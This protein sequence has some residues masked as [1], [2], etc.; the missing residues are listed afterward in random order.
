MHT[1]APVRTPAEILAALAAADDADDAAD[2]AAPEL[3]GPDTPAACAFR[4]AALARAITA[5]AGR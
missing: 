5:A 3:T 2:A 4:R 1:R